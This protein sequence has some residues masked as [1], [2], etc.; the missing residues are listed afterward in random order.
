LELANLKLSRD[1]LSLVTPASACPEK[2]ANK[3][4]IRKDTNTRNLVI[5][6]ISCL[7]GIVVTILNIMGNVNIDVKLMVT[8]KN[9]CQ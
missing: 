8:G 5:F 3:H 6:V 2:L 4:T 9:C 7:H 1:K